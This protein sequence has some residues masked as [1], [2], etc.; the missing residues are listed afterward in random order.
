[1]VKQK[2]LL[3][4]HMS[5]AGGVSNSIKHGI[6]TG[7]TT[8]QIFTRSN[9][10]WVSKPIDSKE[11]EKFL[12]DKNK[13][14]INPVISHTA[15]L[16]NLATPKEDFHKKSLLAMLDEIH[17]AEQLNLPDVVIHPGSPLDQPPEYGMKKIID[18]LNRLIDETPDAKSRIALELTAGQGSQLGYTFEQIVE[19]I[20]GVENRKRLSVCLD[21][22]HI[23]A[24]GYDLR[25]REAYEKT[26]S[27]FDE[28][29]GLKYLKVIHLNDSRKELGSRVD[30]H[31]HIGEGEIGKDAFRFIMQDKRFDN[32]PKILETPKD[33]EDYKSDLKNLAILRKLREQTR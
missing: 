12:A 18:S 32:I 21:T 33:Q 28:V 22:C 30:R 8:I 13:A 5:I 7:C 17:R 3:G 15:Y 31:T 19:M 11:I 4:A 9:N 2:L 29:I 16:I 26:I 1:M 20:D 14:K 10:R 23:F 25:T 27:K 6:N 24:A